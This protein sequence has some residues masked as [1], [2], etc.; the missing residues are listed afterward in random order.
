VRRLLR[1]E[2]ITINE[3]QHFLEISNKANYLIDRL[4]ESLKI[5]KE[6]EKDNKNDI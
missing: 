3:Y 1:K 5:K 4:L 2:Y 6:K